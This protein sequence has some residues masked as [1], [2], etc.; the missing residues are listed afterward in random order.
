MK[1]YFTT[2]K[3]VDFN[4]GTKAVNDTVLILE[5]AGYKPFCLGTVKGDI[6]YRKYRI[7]RMFVELFHLFVLIFT[8][9][10]NDIYF[11]QW[12]LYH[13][14]PKMRSLLYTCIKYKCK[15]L[16]ILIHLEYNL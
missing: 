7:Y 9:S 10:S 3:R 15:H 6:R 1:Y 4:A 11:L 2:E 16:Q 5:K 12:P 13:I 14:M 8:K